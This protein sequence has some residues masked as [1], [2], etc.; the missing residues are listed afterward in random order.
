MTAIACENAIGSR[1]LS[2]NS[3][4]WLSSASLFPFDDG[5]LDSDFISKF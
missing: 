1:H 3:Q 5:I 2:A 4:V